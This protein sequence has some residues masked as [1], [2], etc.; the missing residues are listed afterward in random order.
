M[1]WQLKDFENVL[2]GFYESPERQYLKLSDDVNV[3]IPVLDEALEL[4]NTE[5]TSRMDLVFFG[6]CIQHLSRIARVVQQ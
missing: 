4:Y 3:L 1:E 6:D 5:S 2:F